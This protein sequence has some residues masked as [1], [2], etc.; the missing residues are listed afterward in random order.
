MDRGCCARDRFTL[1]RSAGPFF[2][3]L[4]KTNAAA[5]IQERE[6]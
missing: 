3:M 5:H 2:G 1:G 4:G 6:T